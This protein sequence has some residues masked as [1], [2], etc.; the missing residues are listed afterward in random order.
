MMPV[1]GTESAHGGGYD[2]LPIR[3]YRCH[4][5]WFLYLP[6]SAVQRSSSFSQISFQSRSFACSLEF[7]VHVF[8]GRSTGAVFETKSVP[9]LDKIKANY[10]VIRAEAKVLLDTGVFQRPP[11]VDEPG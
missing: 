5:C 10:P 7:P 4:L 1:L 9:G 2:Q 3:N 8:H 11:S 6:V